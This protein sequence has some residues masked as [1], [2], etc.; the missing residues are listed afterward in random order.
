VLFQSTQWQ[1][2]APGG[3]EAH[4]RSLRGPYGAERYMHASTY[5]KTKQKNLKLKTKPNNYP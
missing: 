2:I 1:F 5:I 3:P 4:M